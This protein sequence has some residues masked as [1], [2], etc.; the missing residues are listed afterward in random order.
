MCK[1]SSLVALSRLL[2][3]ASNSLQS[4]VNACRGRHFT[5]KIVCQPALT[6]ITVVTPLNA[7]SGW[8]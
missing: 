6:K 2:G 4:K 3:A 8:P 5:Q 1:A 7:V